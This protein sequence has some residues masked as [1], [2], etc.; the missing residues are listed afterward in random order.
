MG[1][2]PIQTTTVPN[3]PAVYLDRTAIIVAHRV[4]SLNKINDNF[5]LKKILKRVVKVR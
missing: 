2:I 4:C 3:A 5:S 1:A